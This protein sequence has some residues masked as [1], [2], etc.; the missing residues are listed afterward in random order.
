ML[1]QARA[2]LP[3]ECCGLLAGLPDGRVTHRF[4]LVNEL[5]SPTEFLSDPRSLFAAHK[6]MRRLG[7]DV[8]AVYHSH[9]TS[10]PVPS[11]KDRERNYSP[12]VVNLII[13]LKN[14]T[15]AMRGWWLSAADA[16]EAEW[17]L[18]DEQN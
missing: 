18:A 8:L 6:E 5:A 11:K 17:D 9:P 4:P 16:R 13:S 14:A 1:V 3:H 12:D 7:I 2:E 10:D 15:P